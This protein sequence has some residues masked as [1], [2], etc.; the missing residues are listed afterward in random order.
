MWSQEPP[1]TVSEVVN[2]KMFLGGGHAPRPPRLGMFT[3]AVYY[4][5]SYIPPWEKN[6]TR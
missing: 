3:H 2:L 5:H 1:E 4:C 6:L